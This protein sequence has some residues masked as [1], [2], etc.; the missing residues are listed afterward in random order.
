MTGVIAAAEPSWTASV[1]QLAEMCAGDPGQ[2]R[3][4]YAGRNRGPRDRLIRVRFLR[5]ACPAPHS[6]VE[7]PGSERGSAVRDSCRAAADVIAG[8]CARTPTGS[9]PARRSALGGGR[10]RAGG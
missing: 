6:V 2:G 5:E 3:V 9:L 10:G 4:G 8:A 7:R 1:E